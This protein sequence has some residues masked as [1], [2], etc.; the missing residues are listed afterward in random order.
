M[1]NRVSKGLQ[2]R[3]T[4]EGPHNPRL[5]F[6]LLRGSPRFTEVLQPELTHN[7]RSRHGSHCDLLKGEHHRV[8]HMLL[9]AV[10]WDGNCTQGKES[11]SFLLCFAVHFQ[12]PLLTK[13]DITPAEREY[14]QVKAPV[15]PSWANNGGFGG[16]RQY[17]LVIIWH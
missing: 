1:G 16:E 11:P 8:S 5:R 14:L 7:W 10:P 15:S 2:G 17:R 3:S 6:R 12:C 4:L 9:T 13:S